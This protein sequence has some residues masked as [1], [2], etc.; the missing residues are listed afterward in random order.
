MPHPTPKPCSSAD[1]ITDAIRAIAAQTGRPP[2]IYAFLRYSGFS[3]HHLHKFFPRWND[4]VVAAGFPPNR[5]RQPIDPA[6]LL[7]DWGAT[8]RRIGKI[9]SM[10]RYQN[11]G[12]HNPRTLLRLFH[13]WK[14]IPAAF[15][16]FARSKPEWS[17]VVTLLTL[18]KPPPPQSPAYSRRP[19]HFG[20]PLSIPHMSHQPTEELGVIYLFGLL[21]PR[22]GFTVESLQKRFPDCIAKRQ[23]SGTRWQQ[24]RIEFEFES[25]NFRIHGHPPDG[26]DMIVCWSHNW[27]DCPPNL[28]VLD[29]CT[30]IKN[31]PAV[32]MP[33]H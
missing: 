15:L 27:K 13:E 26:C 18:P 14:N 3:A 33:A 28:E 9:P 30:A 4:A 31:L 7:R 8:V 25:D 19:R 23:L 20:A 6:T 16:D 11:D 12:P 1:E 29:L 24:L 17:D 10:Y 21:A 5:S 2:S 32:P 22:L